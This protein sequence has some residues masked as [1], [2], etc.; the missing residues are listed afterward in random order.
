[1]YYCWISDPTC[2]HVAGALLAEGHWMPR[3]VGCVLTAWVGWIRFIMQCSI[4]F[5]MSHPLWC[6]GNPWDEQLIT[7]LSSIVGE[8][9]LTTFL[10]LTVLSVCSFFSTHNLRTGSCSGMPGHKESFYRFLHWCFW[11]HLLRSG[12]FPKKFVLGNT[13]SKINGFL[14]VFCFLGLPLVHLCSLRGWP[15]QGMSGWPG[16]LPL[17][18]AQFCFHLLYIWTWYDFIFET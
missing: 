8:L 13:N 5:H 14:S 4:T 18:P 15:P 6:Y 11:F 12:L 2:L 1:M 10:E 17:P 16:C 9:S 7:K 3:P